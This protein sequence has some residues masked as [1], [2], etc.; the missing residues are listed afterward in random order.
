MSIYKHAHPVKTKFTRSPGPW[1]KD[2]KINNLQH[3]RDHWQHKVDKNP[4]DENW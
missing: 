2:T 1:M 4:T 3:K